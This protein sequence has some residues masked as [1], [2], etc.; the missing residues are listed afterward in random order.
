MKLAP[1]Q[2]LFRDR[3]LHTGKGRRRPAR[4]QARGRAH[5]G[6]AAAVQRGVGAVEA[7]RGVAAPADPG[8]LG[9]NSAGLA[10]KLHLVPRG[11]GRELEQSAVTPWIAVR[12]LALAV[13]PVDLEQPLFHSVVAPA[14]AEDELAE[15]VDE[16]LA[17]DERELLPVALQV[18]T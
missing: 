1:D 11:H 10:P 5:R 2:V 7:G 6:L 4:G 16:R 3:A 14:A 13:V 9:R 17:A 8:R 18:A 12:E 15:P